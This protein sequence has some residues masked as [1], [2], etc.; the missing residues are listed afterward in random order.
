MVKCLI[1]IQTKVNVQLRIINHCYRDVKVRVLALGPR[2]LGK[3][4]VLPLPQT[5]VSTD[6]GQ[7]ILHR[8]TL[9]EHGHGCRDFA[10]C[11]GKLALNFLLS[12]AHLLSF[13]PNPTLFLRD[14]MD[15]FEKRSYRLC[16]A[17]SRQIL[18]AKQGR[19]WLVLGW[20]TVW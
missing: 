17:Q 7:R 6:Y 12:E 15:L 5:T 1:R 14:F 18:E 16:Y 4:G 13:R 3:G 11:A 20:E 9:Q 2:L 19:A 8:R 10:S